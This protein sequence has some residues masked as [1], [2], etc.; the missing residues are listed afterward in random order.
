MIQVNGIKGQK[1]NL[2][3]PV[4]TGLITFHRVCLFLCFF[5]TSHGRHNY[6]CSSCSIGPRVM[7][8]GMEVYLDN[9]KVDLEDQGHRSKVKVTRS[10]MYVFSGVLLVKL[11]VKGLLRSKITG[12]KV[13]GR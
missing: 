2:I 7:Q 11:D 12:V 6:H 4:Q 13:K 8:F 10:K 5:Q 9:T 3:R 1:E